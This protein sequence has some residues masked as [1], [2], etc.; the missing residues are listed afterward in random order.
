MQSV[1]CV[2][3]LPHNLLRGVRLGS[4]HRLLNENLEH[5]EVFLNVKQA[6]IFNRMR[7][8]DEKLASNA[9]GNVGVS[10]F[11]I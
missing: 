6:F 10:F 11:M 8:K 1:E 2:W 3:C 9:C 5:D 4:L 7:M